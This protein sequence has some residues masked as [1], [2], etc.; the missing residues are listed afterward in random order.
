MKI[1]VTLIVKCKEWQSGVYF[2]ENLPWLTLCHKGPYMMDI[3]E[4]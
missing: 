1:F 3:P 4:S 2:E